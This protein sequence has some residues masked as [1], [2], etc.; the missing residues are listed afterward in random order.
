MLEE[1]QLLLTLIRRSASSVAV[2]DSAGSAATAAGEN[3]DGVDLD[4]ALNCGSATVA[5]PMAVVG[6]SG[7]LPYEV[8]WAA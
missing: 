2:G 6:D 7:I 5:V 1:L 4:F 8:Y 3:A